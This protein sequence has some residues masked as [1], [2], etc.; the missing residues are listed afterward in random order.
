MKQPR[1]SLLYRRCRINAEGPYLGKI[2]HIVGV[3]QTIYGTSVQVK[4]KSV[5]PEY[6]DIK[7]GVFTRKWFHERN[8]DLVVM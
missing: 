6:F 5:D 4:L 3:L 8:V 1:N 2:G 7:Q